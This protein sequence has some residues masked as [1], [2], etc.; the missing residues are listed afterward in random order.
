MPVEAVKK[1]SIYLG[2]TS[3]LSFILNCIL[4]LSLPVSFNYK[5]KT[6][7][8]DMHKQIGSLFLGCFFLVQ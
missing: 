8:S 6:K 2:N 5:S 7:R 1:Y 3:R 4:Y